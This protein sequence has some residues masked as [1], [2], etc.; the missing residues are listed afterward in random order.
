MTSA[1]AF[2]VPSRGVE[3]GD[4]VG[5]TKTV[6][7]VLVVA[8]AGSGA[9][10]DK[11]LTQTEFVTKGNAICESGSQRIDAAAKKAFGTEKPSDAV[12]TEF[13]RDTA[14]PEIQKQLDAL[15]DLTP[16]KDLEAKYDAALKEARSALAK[17]KA[18]PADLASDSSDTFA[19]SDELIKGV[20]LDAC[21][22]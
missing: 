18:N 8:V 11:R 13:V 22:E 12:I 3:T 6:L 5:R 21:V 19:R 20:G 16:P 9:C 14:V 4:P 2:A 10:G 7:V 17:V 15:E 1:P